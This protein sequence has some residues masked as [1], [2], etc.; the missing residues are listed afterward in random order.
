[1]LEE[2]DRLFFRNYS[3]VLG[4]L[5]VMIVIFLILARHY[6]I[7]EAHYI[8]QRA[9]KISETTKPEGEVRIEGE[10]APAAA[11]EVAAAGA[12]PGAA[13]SPTPRPV[14]SPEYRSRLNRPRLAT[15]SVSTRS[16]AW[17]SCSSS[18]SITASG[19]FGSTDRSRPSKALRA[20]S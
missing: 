16:I 19:S 6:G 13:P 2:R 12:A 18:D 14:S 1:M 11:T 10:E 5:A 8:E 4:I 17:F 20:R 15:C 3:I 9:E 7:D